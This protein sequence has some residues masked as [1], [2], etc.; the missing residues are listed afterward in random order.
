M[1]GASSRVASR[2]VMAM[3]VASPIARVRHVN[4]HEFYAVASACQV[5]PTVTPS[6]AR[7]AILAGSFSIDA[8]GRPVL[9]N[10]QPSAPPFAHH[11]RRTMLAKVLSSAVL[12]VDA[13]LV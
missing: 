12:G 9:P 2:I 6:A 4:C 1:A 10:V 5:N 8:A 13:Y 3:S 11:R 7:R